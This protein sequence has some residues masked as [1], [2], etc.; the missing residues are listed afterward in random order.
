MK[1]VQITLW[2]LFLVLTGNS[3]QLKRAKSPASTQDQQS[4]P[5]WFTQPGERPT[6]AP[7]PSFLDIAVASATTRRTQS[8]LI[9]PPSYTRDWPQ[10]A[11]LQLPSELN[12]QTLATDPDAIQW[13]YASE[14]F[15][16]VSDAPLRSEVV[17]E[18]AAFFELT[19]HYC[20]Q[21]P[22]TLD[23]LKNNDDK[24]LQVKLIE[25]YDRYVKEGGSLDS[26]GMYLTSL[27]LI[28][29]PFNGLGLIKTNGSYALDPTRSNR[30][31][32]HEATHMMMRGPLL[33]DGWFVEG[34]AEYVATIPVQEQAL[35]LSNHLSSIKSYITSYGYNNGGGHNL[36]KE[37]QLTSLRQFMECDYAT[38]QEIP[39]SYP[40]S[41]LLFHYFAH[42]DDEGEG[43]RLQAYTKA[44]NSGAERS[45]ARQIL[46]AG[47][48][49]LT[50][51]RELTE[52]WQK[53]GIELRF[54][55]QP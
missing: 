37:I 33:K 55:N 7:A 50:L 46:L 31:L 39:H 4:G 34:A 5:L 23:R 20:G 43:S 30:T 35:I 42:S 48:D 10:G 54:P 11:R 12:I 14:H 24:R 28:L 15:H 19:H 41:L 1:F 8:N 44:L 18:F 45:K 53:E 47:R 32:V 36:S 49:Y 29:V 38:F 51:E 22:I 26:G 16:F 2:S 40:Y 25:N 3:L 27:D 17:R 13:A 52:R 9:P 21:L 6:R